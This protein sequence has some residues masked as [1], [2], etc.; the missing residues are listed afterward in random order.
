MLVKG[1]TELYA[2]TDIVADIW[3]P[4]FLS[5]FYSESEYWSSYSCL[6]LSHLPW[7]SAQNC[8]HHISVRLVKPFITFRCLFLVGNG[9]ITQ[10][11]LH[12]RHLWY[13]NDNTLHALMYDQ[14]EWTHDDVT[15]WGHFQHYW[16]F[17]RG[18]HWSPV[19]PPQKGQ[20]H[21]AF[22]FSMMCAW[23][24]G[25]ANNRDAGDVRYQCTHYDVTVMKSIHSDQFHLTLSM[26]V[27]Q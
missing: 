3:Y 18:I 4:H 2:K 24:S 9:L 5:E 6:L 8:P 21:G 7:V 17:L 1:A 13:S 11:L 26:C 14:V 25:W 16:P 15:K 27:I 12:V 20:L 10:P 22:M 19:D 23:T